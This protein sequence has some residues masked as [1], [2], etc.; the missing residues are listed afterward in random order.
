M[1]S[2]AERRGAGS[3]PSIVWH[4]TNKRYI[5]YKKIGCKS[6]IKPG[7]TSSPDKFA[8]DCKISIS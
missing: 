2:I 4:P 8:G 1:P 3:A 5:S 6:K 7:N